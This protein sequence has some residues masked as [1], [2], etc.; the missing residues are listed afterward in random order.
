MSEHT[1]STG[2]DRRRLIAG[3]G[4]AAGVAGLGAA[5][6]PGRA[7]ASGRLPTAAPQALNPPVVGLSYVAVDGLAF[8]SSN[9]GTTTAGREYNV[10][11][12][13][14]SL[15]APTYAYAPLVLPV[16][17]Q[18]KEL[19]VTYRGSVIAYIDRRQDTAPYWESLYNTGSTPHSATPTSESYEVDIT[20]E[21]GKSYSLR[22]YA[23]DP[24]L[25][26][27]ETGYLGSMHLGYVPPSSGFVPYA[28][29]TPRILD[30][31]LGGGK[32]LA[33]DAGARTLDLGLAGAKAAI[34]NLT[35]DATEAYG[36]FSVYP[37]GVAYPGTSSLNWTT[38][39]TT[40]ANTVIAPLSSDGKI[41]LRAGESAAHAIVDVQGYLF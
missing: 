12:G 9:E 35:A 21:H 19:G 16:G 39:A 18:L 17:A 29:T 3:I 10:D 23:E 30:T 22:F 1:E 7:S 27:F 13:V 37:G 24:I 31:R 20:I 8:H 25:P 36:Y 4:V 33:G 6:V 26:Q 32:V 14:R 5:V 34:I 2:I 41:T 15:T 40:I 28:G 38:A 11:Y